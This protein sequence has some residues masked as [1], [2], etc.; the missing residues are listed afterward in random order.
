M[1]SFTNPFIFET[2]GDRAGFTGREALLPVLLQLMTE[3]GRR[4]VMVG[5]RRMGKT[6]LI[7]TAADKARA[8]FVYCDLATATSLNEVARNLMGAVPQE[9]G[10][11]LTQALEIAAKYLKNVG[12]SAGKVILNGELRPEDGRQTLEGVLHFLNERAA[13]NFEVWTVCLDE[14]QEMRVLGGAQNDWQL[15][16][17]TQNHRSLNY[18]F[19][20]SDRRLAGWM[21]EP[22]GPEGRPWQE[23][24]VGPVA[25]D[26]LA[27]WIDRR[28]RSG[29]LRNFSFGDRIVAAAGPCTGDSVRLGRTVFSLATGRATGDLVAMAFDAI[30]LGE[31]NDE[32]LNHWRSLPA[33]QRGVLRAIADGRAPMAADTLREYGLRAASSASTAVEALV[34]RQFL[35]RTDEG[36]VFDSPYFRRWVAFHGPPRA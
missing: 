10:L 2:P 27:R 15:H 28:A 7:R 3:R 6:A 26:D 35:V 14:F 18:L 11:R 33:N 8:A 4:L 25:G 34:E 17:P 23:I 36:V 1:A 13:A 31:R 22:P 24:E 21:K 5:R 19:V 32:F 9:A 20:G 30:A 29:G 12:V 16:G